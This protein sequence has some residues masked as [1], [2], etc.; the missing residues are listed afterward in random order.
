[1][2]TASL[3]SQTGYNTSSWRMD[4]KRSSS[5]SAS[6]GGCPAIIS[7]M[8]TP[9]AHQSTDGPYSSSWRIWHRKRDQIVETSETTVSAAHL[10]FQHDSPSM[11]Q[12]LSRSGSHTDFSNSRQGFLPMQFA[13]T[14]LSV[15]EMLFSEVLTEF[16]SPL[17]KQLCLWAKELHI[18]PSCLKQVTL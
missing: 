2:L 11:P 10:L 17:S 14:Q 13:L 3:L 1:M 7:Y 8:R 18:L 9:R 4:S 5:L 6:K 16:I 15:N 12:C